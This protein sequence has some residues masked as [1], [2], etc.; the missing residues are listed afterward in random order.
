[1]GRMGAVTLI[2]WQDH[3]G[4]AETCRKYLFDQRWPNGFVCS[5]CQGAQYY[6]V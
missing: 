1:M 5:R 3:F 4:T 2:E 6:K